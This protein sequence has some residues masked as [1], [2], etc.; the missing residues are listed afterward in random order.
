MSVPGE[1]ITDAGDH[2]LNPG[3]RTLTLVVQNG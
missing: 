1:L 2:V 3:R